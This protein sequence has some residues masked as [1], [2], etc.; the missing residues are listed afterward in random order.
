M[1]Q[2]L[3]QQK[4]GLGDILFCQGISNVFKK[5]GYDIIWPVVPQLLESGLIKSEFNFNKVMR[6]YLWSTTKI[7]TQE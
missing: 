7:L 4:C 5:Q 1:K 6:H 3:M 2:V